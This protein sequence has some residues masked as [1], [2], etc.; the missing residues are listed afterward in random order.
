MVDRLEHYF[1]TYKVMPG[2]DTTVR[3]PLVYGAEHARSVVE[4]SMADYEELFGARDR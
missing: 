3:I 4:A 2:R 1:L